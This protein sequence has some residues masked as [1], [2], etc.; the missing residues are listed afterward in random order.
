MTG[1][2]DRFLNGRQEYIASDGSHWWVTCEPKPSIISC[3][4]EWEDLSPFA[5]T[6]SGFDWFW[7]S[8]SDARRRG[9]SYS[10]Q[11]CALAIEWRIAKGWQE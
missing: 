1:F 8:D 5:E 4:F 2:T 3:A 6:T 7:C 10:R 9:E 11:A